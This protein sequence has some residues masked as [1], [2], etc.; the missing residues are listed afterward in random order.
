[1]S[2]SPLPRFV[3]LRAGPRRGL[4]FLCL[5]LLLLC[6]GSV[7][8]D[9]LD[10]RS[11]SDV[12]RD[13]GL[14][15]RQPAI[16]E[17]AKMI[18]ESDAAGLVVAEALLGDRAMSPAG[19]TADT[20]SEIRGIVLRGIAGRPGSAYGRLLL[21][22]SAPATG[23]TA[24]WMRPFEL[25]VTAAPGLDLAT[26]E[27]AQRYIAAWRSL[28]TADRPKAASTIRRAFRSPAFLRASLVPALS[29]LGPGLTVRVLPEDPATLRNAAQIFQES[30]QVQA[31]ELL[32]ARIK[33]ASAPAE[34]SRPKD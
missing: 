28:P 21:G 10:R 2:A 24:L 8:W 23:A 34:A 27:L 16:L 6:F 29:T 5:F 33:G 13:R 31:A 30:G 1:M 18:D 22:R 32:A 11:W 19:P 17:T 15:R 20:P 4:V 14:A 9:A 3:S 12:A 7:A 25:A 26:S